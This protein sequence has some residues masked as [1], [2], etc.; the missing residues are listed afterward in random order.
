M[1]RSRS[2]TARRSEFKQIFAKR[3][4][5]DA[6]DCERILWARLRN[7]Q[8]NGFRFRRQQ[9]I[10]PFVADFYC[11]VA[12]LVVE[13]DGSQHGADGNRAYDERRTQ[14]LSALGYR[15]L[16][17]TNQE[18]LQ[19]CEG[20]LESIARAIEFAPPRTREARSTLPQGEG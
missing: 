5:R 10:G 9:P 12:K 8:L 7:G 1:A 14:Y 15:V 19:N 16:R 6:T 17:F 4:R 20:V 13:L 3:L 2:R 11:S 18:L